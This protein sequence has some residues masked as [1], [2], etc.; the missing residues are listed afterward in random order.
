MPFR[1]QFNALKGKLED[2]NRQHNILPIGQKSSNQPGQHQ[3]YPGWQPPPPQ[4]QHQYPNQQYQNQQFQNQQYHQQQYHQQQYQEQQHQQHQ[5][6]QQQQSYQPPPVPGHSRPPE[7]GSIGPRPPV[8]PP[9][10]SNTTYWRAN[11]SGDVPVSHEWE[12]KTG[13]NNGWGNAELEHYTSN[14][15]NSYFTPDSKLVLCAISRP[16]HPDHAQKYTSARLVS[17]QSLSRPR[18]SLTTYLSLPCAEGIWPAFWLLPREPFTWPHDGE[19]DI[20]ES[21][22]GDGENHSCLHWGFYNAED[23]KKHIVKGTQVPDMRSGRAIRYDFVWDEGSRR[24][25][26]SIDGRGVMRTTLPQGLR[27]LE[28]FCVIINVAMGGNV[29]GGKVPPEGS[30]AMVVHEVTMSEEPEGGWAKFE[31]DWQRCPEGGLM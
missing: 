31:Q 15:E 3:Q 28:D 4:Q 21:W 17:R 26:W 30:Y 6:Q 22:N 12:Q 16:H 20:A 29:C 13:N 2:L 5:Q 8:A 27:R 24:L 1:D 19:V 23:H 14:P 18:G 10:S 11:L 25:M 7:P 9:P